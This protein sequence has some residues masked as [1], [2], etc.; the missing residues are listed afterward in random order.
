MPRGQNQAARAAARRVCPPWYPQNA[1][2]A[3]AAV[4]MSSAPACAASALS[5][6][7]ANMPSVVVA[8][9][10][11]QRDVAS[12]RRDKRATHLRPSSHAGRYWTFQACRGCQPAPVRYGCRTGAARCAQP[13]D[14]LARTPHQA[15]RGLASCPLP[16]G[17]QTAGGDSPAVS[18]LLATR[19]RRWCGPSRPDATG[20]SGSSTAL[21]TAEISRRIHPSTA[22]R[23][24]VLMCEQGLTAGVARA[25]L[26]LIVMPVYTRRFL[27]RRGHTRPSQG[28]TRLQD[29][30]C[31]ACRRQNG[32][33]PG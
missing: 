30:G 26:H 31:H 28:C 14:T 7:Y 27:P 20:C 32:Q 29:C 15:R 2:K 8:C 17:F 19:S 1:D 33:K 13:S 25:I 3:G 24:I 21:V 18:A 4:G 11:A 5:G 9:A 10:S 22:Q 23:P 12:G 6:E 16:T